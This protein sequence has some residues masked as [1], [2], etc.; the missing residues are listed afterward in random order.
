MPF[1]DAI[2]RSEF[3]QALA[4][5][6]ADGFEQPI[7]RLSC[8]HAIDQNDRFVDESSESS[9]RLDLFRRA[10][11]RRGRL[12]CPSTHEYR[13]VAKRE[14]L[15]TGQRI[16][17]RLKRRE[18]R[19]PARNRSRFADE[20][21]KAIVEFFADLLD[22]QQS[23]T[24]SRELEGQWNAVEPAADL[25]DTRG[26]RRRQAKLRCGKRRALD[27]PQNGLV[28]NQQFRGIDGLR[29]REAENNNNKTVLRAVFSA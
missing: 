7:A 2:A 9:E 13:P 15:I 24:R 27:E 3:F 17:S 19:L 5:E 29:V 23:H 22:G 16:E 28:A 25:R 10:I 21:S 8:A 1:A 12:Q 18:Q 14:L 26:V 20:Q 11:D 4:C 6:L